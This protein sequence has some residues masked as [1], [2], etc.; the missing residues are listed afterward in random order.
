MYNSKKISLI[1]P[2]LNEKKGLSEI[3]S[4]KPCFIDEVVVVD[5]GSTDE[6]ADV[7]RAYGATV[8]SL[9]EKGY[10]GA[11]QAGIRVAKGD[12]II[13]IDGDA[14]YP[15]TEIE[16]LLSYMEKE[17][18]DFLTGCRF[19]LKN[20][21]AMPVY[22]QLSNGLFSWF[23]R[24]SFAIELVDAMTGM[25]VFKRNFWPIIKCTNK[26]M[27]FSFE[28]KL[29]AWLNPNVKSAELYIEYR[30]RLGEVK[31]RAAYDGLKTVY[32][33]VTFFCYYRKKKDFLS[34]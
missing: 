16:A 10:G 7:A 17:G 23:L 1:I 21:K 27:G 22:K 28:L 3:F 29:N 13:L 26:G 9:F 25:F 20:K 11:H 8:V 24:K 12:I 4:Q 5:N 30:P 34:G 32:D 31:F 15:V 6:T 14:T 33:M 18:V 19:P 2:C